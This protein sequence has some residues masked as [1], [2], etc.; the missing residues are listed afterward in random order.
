MN[1]ITYDMLT[2]GETHRDRLRALA[3]AATEEQANK[4]LCMLADRI[5][6]PPLDEW[7]DTVVSAYRDVPQVKVITVR[8]IGFDH[9]F[10]FWA[11]IYF[12]GFETRNELDAWEFLPAPKLPSRFGYYYCMCMREIYSLYDIGVHS[13]DRVVYLRDDKGD[14]ER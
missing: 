14:G 3:D 9:G 5:Y 10:E 12:D 6:I 11:M 2:N 4:V 8:T 7:V 13:D 1:D